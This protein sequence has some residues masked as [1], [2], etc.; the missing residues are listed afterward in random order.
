MTND[1]LASGETRDQRAR[2]LPADALLSEIYV[3]QDVEGRWPVRMVQ[4]D[5]RCSG[6][7]EFGY[8]LRGDQ[9]VF[10]AAATAALMKGVP[11]AENGFTLKPVKY[12]P[13]SLLKVDPSGYQ[14]RPRGKVPAMLSDICPSGIEVLHH[15]CIA[16]N[17]GLVIA[18]LLR[19]YTQRW[20]RERDMPSRMLDRWTSFS[21]ELAVDSVNKDY[22]QEVRALLALRRE[23][24]LLPDDVASCAAREALSMLTDSDAG[25]SVLGGIDALIS[26]LMAV[27]SAVERDVAGPVVK[28]SNRDF[29]FVGQSGIA[30]R[31]RMV[32]TGDSFG[33]TRHGKTVAVNDGP[34]LV[35]V[36]D[37]RALDTPYGE[38]TGARYEIGHYERALAAGGLQLSDQ[39]PDWV[40]GR[41]D[42]AAVVDWARAAV[43]DLDAPVNLQ[44][45][46]M[47]SWDSVGKA[48]RGDVAFNVYKQE[49]DGQVVYAV[50]KE[51]ET[52]SP[53]A[54]GYSNLDALLKIKGLTFV[55]DSPAPT[56]FAAPDFGL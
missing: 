22:G 16:E 30:F 46:P 20:V 23:S 13:L 28:A 51:G 32:L 53:G 39:R 3:F 48:V 37:A 17:K 34:T 56:R 31:A 50:R 11:G 47:E 52:I 42:L 54:G 8:M 38:F 19:D 12:S 1:L 15:V 33:F 49:A 14:D 44:Y 25:G 41:D 29:D 10:S 40:L 35:E 2:D 26:R 43:L 21:A 45:G 24:S 6:V 7:K 27:R 5:F 36:Y 9:M 4:R 55:P 18:N